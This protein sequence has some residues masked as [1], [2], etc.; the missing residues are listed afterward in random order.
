MADADRVRAC[1]ETPSPGNVRALLEA[2]QDR[3][4]NVCRQVLRHPEDAEDAA[5]EALLKIAAGVVSGTEFRNFDPWMYRVAFYAALN[6]LKLKKRRTAHEQRR[7]QMA[8]AATPPDEAYEA[9]HEALGALDD[10]ARCVIVRHFFEQRTLEDLARED[11]CSPVAVWKRIEK[12]KTTL[13][14]SLLRSGTGSYASLLDG[15]FQSIRP[16]AAPA[17][18]VS[19]ALVAKAVLPLAPAAPGAAAAA[20]GGI[21]MTGKGVSLGTLALVSLLL[22]FSGM[23][24]AYLIKAAPR[25]PDLP[26]AAN[27]AIR[28]ATESHADSFRDS[29]APAA[30][31]NPPIL[32]APPARKEPLLGKLQ[33]LAQLI[34]DQMAMAKKGDLQPLLYQELGRKYAEAWR[35]LRGQ[36]YDEPAE[37]FAF[38]RA[39]E[40]KDIF[41]Q[42][43][44]LLGDVATEDGKSLRY[45]PAILDGLKDLIATGTKVQRRETA[46]YV[47]S[48]VF[49]AGGAGTTLNELCF[50]QLSVEKD[51]DV[52]ATLINSLHITSRERFNGMERIEKRLELL[53]EIWQNNRNWSVREQSLEVLANA[54][55]SAGEALFLEKMD[56]SLRG[57]DKFLK[58]YLPQIL[59]ARLRNLTPGDEDKY[60]PLFTTAFHEATEPQTCLRYASMSLSLPL[61]KTE[62]LLNEARTHAPDAATKAALERALDL[63]HQGETRTDVLHQ[64]LYKPVKSE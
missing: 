39:P 5:Q 56:E 35:T 38:L 1:R 15:V 58:Q 25:P 49:G 50:E 6:A 52:L 9:V 23:G 40:N 12:A 60:L 4:Y 63:I 10:D 18:L 32:P 8:A 14:E 26:P 48:S 7:A 24:G 20:V 22:F 11:H 42:L 21:A 59:D 36:V 29:A 27:A 16:A 64:S 37:F 46:S 31:T 34:R 62:L 30:A 53:Q 33:A 2:C 3:V 51:P 57:S 28:H 17:G 45:P 47:T 44:L 61:P 13:K 55:T 19:E 41:T 43:L 54:R